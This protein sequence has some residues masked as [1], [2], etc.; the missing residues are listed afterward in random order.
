MLKNLS[1]SLSNAFRKLSGNEKITPNNIKEAIKEI[2]LCLIEA[3]VAYEVAN[4]VCDKIKSEA[5]GQKIADQL[6]PSEALMGI[7]HQALIEIMTSKQ[8][9]RIKIKQNGLSTILLVGLQAAGKTTFASKLANHFKEQGKSVLLTST[10]IHRPAA[11]EQLKGLADKKEVAYWQ[12]PDNC[13][14]ETITKNAID[15]AQQQHHD[16]L[17]I[18]T[19]GRIPKDLEK[20]TELKKIEKAA[21]PIETLLVIDAMS[22][23]DAATTTKLFNQSV[24]LSGIILTKTDAES[25]AGAALS[26]TWITG[27]PIKLIGYGEKDGISEFSAEN[28][29]NQILD[30][31]DLTGLIKTMEQHAN[32]SRT[33]TMT[34]KI[35]QGKFDFN[36]FLYQLNMLNNMGGLGK[37]LSML[38]GANQMEQ[39]TENIDEKEFTCWRAIIQS[40]TEWERSQP[41]LMKIRSR[42]ERIRKGAGVSNEAMKSF[43]KKFNKMQKSLKR[44]SAL[45]KKFGNLGQMS[46]LFKN[47]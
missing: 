12:S 19:A 1:K 41:Q 36:D 13:T 20:I 26:C 47:N 27:L 2:Q 23:Q 17:I 11:M 7:T 3:D 46:D 33:E 25:R 38:P 37:I 30:Q 39:L 45:T 32:Q 15:H 24:S 14:P 22:G 42:T 18:D 31:G 43:I 40:M 6:S 10:D 29:A 8:E 16:V 9:S 28:T 44:M 5:I 34:E 4:A 21:K 35:K